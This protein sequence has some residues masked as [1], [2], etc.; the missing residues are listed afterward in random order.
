M[1]DRRSPSLAWTNL[2][3]WAEGDDFRAACARLA[4]RHAETV[5]LQPSHR[6]LDLACGRG[7]SLALWWQLGVRE[8]TGLDADAEALRSAREG[9]AGHGLVTDGAAGVTLLSGRYDQ[10]PPVPGLLPAAHDAV[11]CIDAAYHA[12]S[13]DAFLRTVAH[14]LA[15]DGRAAWSTLVLRSEPGWRLRLLL[16]AAGIP[17][18]SLCTLADWQARA[19]RHGLL[20]EPV[21]ALDAEVLDGFSTF[22]RSAVTATPAQA[23]TQGWSHVPRWKLALTGRLCRSLTASGEI[24]YMLMKTRHKT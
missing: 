15:P 24:G 23:A 19:D 21:A 17:S 1:S 16:R 4:R 5:S 14:V 12:S 6:V 9:L 20:L 8:L 11:V 7:A 13:A 2:G 22:A 10:W 18:A 3:D